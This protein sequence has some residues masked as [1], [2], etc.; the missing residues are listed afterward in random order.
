V[1]DRDLAGAA[2]EIKALRKKLEGAIKDVAREVRE[3]QATL[4]AKST[5]MAAYDEAFGGVAAV[6][7]GLLRL[8]GKPDLAAKVRPSPR[9]PGQTAA[10][11]GDD[12]PPA[13]APA[14]PP[15]N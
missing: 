7:M 14:D 1:R 15:G 2:A 11:A 8:S 5:A 10:D 3:A 13:P 9:R 12:P 4:D 6:L